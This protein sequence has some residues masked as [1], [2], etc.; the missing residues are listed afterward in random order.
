MHDHRDLLQAHRLMTHRMSQALLCG[1]PDSRNRPL[2]RMYAASACAVLVGVIAAGVFAALGV[3]LPR[4]GHV[5]GLNQPGTLVVDTDTMTAFV[6]CAGGELCP[7]VNFASALLALDSPGA[8]RRV[9]VTTAALAGY[10]IG[11]AV[12]I[13]GLPP[14]LPAASALVHGPWS[15]CTVGGATVLVGGMSTG[16]RALG[17]SDAALVS[18]EGGEW[19]LWD[20]TRL[21]IQPAVA[22]TLFDTG[23]VSVPLAWL[24]SLPRGPDFAAPELPGA[25]QLVAGPSGADSVAGQVYVQQS[26]PQ[27]YVLTA[28]GRLAPVTAVAAALLERVPGAQPGP[29][30]LPLNGGLRPGQRRG[31]DGRAARDG[32]AHRRGTV[33][34]VRRLRCRAG[35]CGDRR[36]DGAIWGRDSRRRAR[37]VPAGR[38]RARPVGAGVVPAGRRAPVPGAVS[39]GRAGARLQPRPGRRPAPR[40]RDRPA[41]ARSRA[42]SSRGEIAGGLSHPWTGRER[43]PSTGEQ[44]A[45]GEPAKESEVARMAAG[46]SAVN[47][48]SMAQ[49]G[50]Q[51]EAAFGMI[52]GLQSNMN[53]YS[54]QLGGGWQGNA[55]VAFTRTYEMF[56]A[57]FAKVLNALQVIHDKL[58]STR[59]TYQATEDANTAR[60]NQVAGLISGGTAMTGAAAGKGAV[61]GGGASTGQGVTD[62]AANK[63]EAKL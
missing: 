8:T 30:D 46:E 55:A 35:A 38:R 25:G 39:R 4:S 24:D 54:S 62:I 26:P 7:A 3:F 61:K 18:A 59:N 63:A 60:V 2:R 42:R 12:G 27:F 53:G 49:A 19:L 52:T 15:V 41:R 47:R 23:P 43:T 21:A 9:A 40:E 13:A 34:A 44:I 33:A 1:E 51:V 5:T 37:M 48:A 56:S 6:P 57:D 31:A 45:A 22:Q 36:R 28:S 32:A 10:A 16:G 11:P 29:A 58:V 50:Q 14:M 17:P 20:S